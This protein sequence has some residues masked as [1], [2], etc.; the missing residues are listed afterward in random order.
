M[1][2]FWWQP[3]VQEILRWWLAVVALGWLA[4]PLC[5]RCQALLPDRGLLTAKLAGLVLWAFIRA[6]LLYGATAQR[7]PLGADAAGWWAAAGVAALSAAALVRSG[8]ATLAWTWAHRGTVLRAEVAFAAVF[9]AGLWLRSLIPDATWDVQ[10]AGAEKWGNLAIL[11]SVWR[12]PIVPPLDPWLA[13]YTLNYYFFGHF[14]WGSLARLAVVAP[15]VAFN[16]AMAT[17]G[18]LLALGAWSAG[19]TLSERRS[20]GWWALFLVA[21][22]GTPITWRQA[23]R[24]LDLLRDQG[25]AAMLRGFDFWGP[26]S[27]REDSRYE[28]PAF[29]WLLGDLHAHALGLVMLLW[30]LCLL[31]QLRQARDNDGGGA[32]WRLLGGQAPTVALLAVV[33]GSLWATNGWDVAVLGLVVLGW[34]GL[35]SVRTRDWREGLTLAVT[36]TALAGLFGVVAMRF[37]AAFFQTETQMPLIV[38][39]PA[40][41]KLPPPL[42]ALG[43][44]GGVGAALRTRPAEWL[45]FWGFLAAPLAWV[46]VPWLARGKG[47]WRAAVGRHSPVPAIAAAVLLALVLGRARVK[48]DVPPYVAVGL[49]LAL[50]AVVVALVRGVQQSRLTAVGEWAILLGGVSLVLQLVPEIVYV[51]DPISPSLPRYNTVFKLYYPA[52]GLAALASALVLS[53]WTAARRGVR[54]TASPTGREFGVNDPA[55][56]KESAPVLPSEETGP[57]DPVF[58]EFRGNAQ[59]AVEYLLG[60][61]KGEAAGALHHKALG[62]IDLPWGAEGTEHGD[63]WGLATIAKYHPEVLGDLQG[64][65]DST[66]EV[67]RTEHRVWLESPKYE[68]VVRLDWDGRSKTWLLT[69]Y[70]KRGEESS[71][72]GRTDVPGDPTS[73]GAG[74][75]TPPPG[76]SN[77][78]VAEGRQPVKG[79]EELRNRSYGSRG[80]EGLRSRVFSRCAVAASTVALSDGAGPDGPP[81]PRSPLAPLALTRQNHGLAVAAATLFVIA[82]GAYA[83]LGVGRRVALAYER[84]RHAV[85]DQG[86]APRQALAACRTLDATAF[87]ALPD[88]GAGDDRRL[89]LWMRDR[90]RRDEAEG[91]PQRSGARSRTDSPGLSGE[92]EGFLLE[93]GSD[94]Y[95]MAGRFAVLSGVPTYLGWMGHE[96][97]WRGDK[98]GRDWQQRSTVVELIYGSEDAE[99][100]REVCRNQRI[101]WVAVGLLERRQ[102]AD[103]PESLRKF[104]R[105]GRV[106]H[107][108]GESALYEIDWREP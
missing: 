88:Y 91:L 14:V 83:M 95:T 62:E 82:A 49:A 30:A 8:R 100:A 27:I 75:T 1:T 70:E 71:A 23:P 40:L 3:F 10:W 90:W 16:L 13:G 60:V 55:D 63:G 59:G 89:G 7:W 106:V 84:V 17:L 77:T 69:A 99:E 86:V 61:R 11:T 73:G 33:V 42:S 94:S 29:N 12:H 51:A 66:E 43:S 25:F 65:L 45:A 97:Q 101:R 107:R 104:D 87:L 85:A 46:T 96:V 68:G 18:G 54:E 34:V 37:L 58:R 78:I 44:L 81:G 93:W 39:H 56:D 79:E 9:G 52:W 67:R 47:I 53:E 26:S 38:L 48:G 80:T 102:F 6:W 20:G 76:D 98:F 15:P 35:E 105:I 32:W 22:A 103:S 24:L 4:W 21:V 57:F 19:R 5:F 31:A 36:G 64:V 92:T 72:R 28:F 2:A 41:A 74:G 50:L 108:E